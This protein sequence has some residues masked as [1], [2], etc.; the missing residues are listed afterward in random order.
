MYE[1][2]IFA[3]TNKHIALFRSH[4]C[5]Y[6]LRIKVSTPNCNT[7]NF[8]FYIKKSLSLRRIWHCYIY[9]FYIM[10]AS[11]FVRIV[12]WFV[13]IAVKLSIESRRHI[14]RKPFIPTFPH[15]ATNWELKV[16][17]CNWILKS[18][19]QTFHVYLK[20]YI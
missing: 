20:P 19:M 9:V 6:F 7:T 13:P 18:S 12:F 11:Y 14:H 8:S 10:F 17:T 15:T 4:T 16:I 2:V 5:P 1:Y 3:N